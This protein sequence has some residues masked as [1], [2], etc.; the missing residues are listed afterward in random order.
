MDIFSKKIFNK[1]NW[2]G[3]EADKYSVYMP[4]PETRASFLDAI[5][6]AKP[7]DKL[8]TKTCFTG[9]RH[10]EFLNY[11]VRLNYANGKVHGG[12]SKPAM[13]YY[14]YGNKI[15]ARAYATHGKFSGGYIRFGKANRKTDHVLS[16]Q[17]DFE[18]SHIGIWDTLNAPIWKHGHGISLYKKVIQVFDKKY[19]LEDILDYMKKY[20][21]D[22]QNL[23]EAD[24]F[25]L[26]LLYDDVSVVNIL[27]LDRKDIKF[28][29]VFSY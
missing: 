24:R 6:D 18:F 7:N 11:H 10:V 26:S 28:I 2:I 19:Y 27:G 14:D 9:Q 4:T 22:F 8:S 13:T 15:I 3:I 12:K 21:I 29:D 1:P 17:D 25:Q 16:V 23:C 20:H 5:K